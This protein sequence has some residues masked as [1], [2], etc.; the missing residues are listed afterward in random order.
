MRFVIAGS[1]TVSDIIFLYDAIRELEID[2]KLITEVISGNARGAD[3]LGEIYAEENSLPLT[4]MPAEW[5]KFGKSA[6]YRRN[7]DM[8]KI[9]DAVICLWAGE[10]RGTKHM[11]DLAVKYNRKLW[12]YDVSKNARWKNIQMELARKKQE[13]EQANNKFIPYKS[14]R[15]TK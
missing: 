1:R 8:A 3:R 4:I 14:S 6:G 12:V 9:C 5:E 7:E 15:N 10:S 13:K 11:M 2:E